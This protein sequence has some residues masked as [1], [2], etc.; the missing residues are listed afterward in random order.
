MRSLKDLTGKFLIATPVMDDEQFYKSVIYIHEYDEYGAMGFV[1]NKTYEMTL[2]ALLKRLKIQVDGDIQPM[3]VFAGGPVSRERG[4]VLQEKAGKIHVSSSVGT[5]S[6][7]ARG[8]GSGR[9]LVS[10]GY[11]SWVAGQL[12]EE[13][14]DH[15]WIVVQECPS[16]LFDTPLALRWEE[17]SAGMGIDF[18]RMS[19][20]VGHA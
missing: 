17:A 7:V 6:A 11:T 9:A 3:P 5:L 2:E 4:F 19:S 16:I 13:I 10:L 20:E 1:I 8:K 18:Y 15:Y 12:E 14:T